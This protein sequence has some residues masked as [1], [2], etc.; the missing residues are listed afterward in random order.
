MYVFVHSNIGY[1][2]S[3]HHNVITSICLC[4]LWIEVRTT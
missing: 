4:D 2:F 3:G 1:T